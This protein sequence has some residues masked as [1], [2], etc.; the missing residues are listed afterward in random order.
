MKSPGV[1]YNADI[2]NNGTA[3]RVTETLVQM[4]FL[5]TGMKRYSRNDDFTPPEEHDFW[6]YIDDGRDEIPMPEL[7]SPNACWLVDTHL[8]Y[9]TRLKWARKF[10][11]VFLCQKPDVEKMKK[12]GVDNVHWL[13]LACLPCVDPNISELSELPKERLGS[14]GLKKKHNLVFVGHLNE[15]HEGS[16]NNRLQYLDTA[17]SAVPNNW[18]A[19]GEFFEQAAIRFVRGRVGFNI[20]I[21]D[22]LNM[23]FF[24]VMSSGTCLLTNTDVVGIEDLGF[25]EDVHFVG[26]KG[27]EDVGEKARWCIDNPMEREKIAKEGHKLVRSSHTYEHRLNEMLKTCE[28][29]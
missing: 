14:Y 18:L 3:R 22:D 7:P 15:G 26:Y 1:L 29:S 16:G 20:S 28:V 5:D 17:F 4:G 8:G 2:R 19:F 9:D 11:F 6:L 27:L 13:P 21:R 25:E 12:D 10:D 23:C 24:E